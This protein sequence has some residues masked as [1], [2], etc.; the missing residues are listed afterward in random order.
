MGHALYE[1]NVASQLEGTPLG[2]GVSLGVHESQSRLWENLV[3]RSRNFWE[4]WF[5]HLREAFPAIGEVSQ[6][7]F[8]RAINAVK[9]SLIRTEADEV[10]YNL[11]VV[12][13]YEIENELLENRLSVHDA[14]AAWNAKMREYFG[15]EPRDAGEGILQD[16]HWLLGA[17]GYFPTYSLGNIWSVQLWE[18]AL[19]AHPSIPE[20]IARGEYSQ[21]R[22]WLRENVHR[23][24]RAMLPGV[25]MQRA[26][27]KTL[28]VA[29]YANYL[30]EKY[31][32]LYGLN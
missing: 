23:H 27:G 7:D 13:R 16:V 28:D 12:L 9:P 14:P 24:G 26:T 10:T 29:P 6:D 1:Q 15:I 31:A 32:P 2:G 22:D 21:L 11:H 4:F 8:Y 20:D 25:L 19:K 3:G 30:R 18:A 5:P 17:I